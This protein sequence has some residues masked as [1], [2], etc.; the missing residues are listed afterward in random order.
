MPK[1]SDELYSK[2]LSDYAS[3]KSQKAVGEENGICRDAVGKILKRN[4]VEIRKYTGDR[5][6]QRKWFWDF[7]FFD[8][9]TPTTAYWAG[10]MLADGHVV[11]NGTQRSL[12]VFVAEK[13]TQ[14]IK[15]FCSDIG[16]PD[17][18]QVRNDG[19]VGAILNHKDIADSLERWGIIPRKSKNFD[20]PS[21]PEELLPHFLRG[22]IDG[23][24]SVY[25]HGTGARI[26]VSSGN[27]EGLIWLADAFRFL[28]FTGNIGV[29]P[30]N[31]IRYPGNFVLYIGGKNNVSFIA[32][33]LLVDDYFCLERKWNSFYNTK[34]KL[35]ERNCEVCGNTFGVSKYRAE[36]E[37]R[38]G[39][40]CSR[41]C[42]NAYQRHSAQN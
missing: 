28:G 12:V 38:N 31:D 42:F 21:F 5:Q 17:L 13:D 32:D 23:D 10:F 6:S 16:N 25:R 27:K 36:N 4:F 15:Q 3:G 40:F 14:H 34:R 9:N 29:R 41:D 37:P 24:G 1:L 35:L 20:V 19:Y 39:R 22:W 8:K 11:K 2:I 30:V 18:F 7:S 33:M 26:V